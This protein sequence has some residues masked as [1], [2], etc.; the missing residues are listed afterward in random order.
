ML[1]LPKTLINRFSNVLVI[2]LVDELVSPNS[3]SVCR[4]HFK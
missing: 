2:V 4:S 3:Y 1:I